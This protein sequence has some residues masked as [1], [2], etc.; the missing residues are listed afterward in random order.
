MACL[1]G[2]LLVKELNLAKVILELDCCGV[3]AKLA[4]GDRDRSLYG[5]LIEDIKHLLQ[6][7][8]DMVIR[9]IRREANGAAHIMAKEG[10]DGRINR[11]W[12][13]VPPS[14]VMDTLVK[15]LSIA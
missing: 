9:S 1:H 5:S 6:G 13:A 8:G 10:C 14:I 11:V 4:N 2:L 12:R 15:D 7:F 3:A